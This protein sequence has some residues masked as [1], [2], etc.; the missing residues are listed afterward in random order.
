NPDASGRTPPLRR[1]GIAILVVSLSFGILQPTQSNVDVSRDP[2][3]H[4][5]IVDAYDCGKNRRLA[6]PAVSVNDGGALDM[7]RWITPILPWSLIH[8]AI[9]PPF[10]R[11]PIKQNAQASGSFM[12][13]NQLASQGAE[14][15]GCLQPFEANIDNSLLVQG[16]NLDH[17]IRWSQLQ[18]TATQ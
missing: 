6:I 17:P 13:G 8:C 1:P 14:L 10:E 5:A 11:G 16:L 2:G 12:H 3:A 4:P 9:I 18:S 15:V 7:L